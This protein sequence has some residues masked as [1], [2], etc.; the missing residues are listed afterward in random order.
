M[1]SMAERITSIDSRTEEMCKDLDAITRELADQ[2]K[3]IDDLKL[4]RARLD[5][6]IDMLWKLVGFLGMSGIIA[7]V[8]A[9]TS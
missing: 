9:F 7:L 2:R 4:A 3:D 6:Q 1:P 5:G 8:K